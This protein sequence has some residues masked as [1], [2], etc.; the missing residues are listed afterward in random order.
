MLPTAASLT[1]SKMEERLEKLFAKGISVRKDTTKTQKPPKSYLQEVSYIQET[2]LF[3]ILM[4][5]Y[6]SLIE[7]KISSSAV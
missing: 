6:R 5:Q 3:G 1:S 7:P 4:E 2:L